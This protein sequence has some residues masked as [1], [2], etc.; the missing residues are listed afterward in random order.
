MT[1]SCRTL[2]RVASPIHLPLQNE[3][4]VLRREL[5]GH[6]EYCLRTRFRLIPFVW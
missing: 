4:K 5:P 1:A 6:A 3:E 2:I